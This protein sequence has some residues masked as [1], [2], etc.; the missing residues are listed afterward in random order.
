MVDE[1]IP[2]IAGH[3]IASAV[4]HALFGALARLDHLVV[5][6]EPDGPNCNPERTLTTAT[7][8]DQQTHVLR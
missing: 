5:H 3:G 1:D 8:T 4:R 7:H 2:L 6:V